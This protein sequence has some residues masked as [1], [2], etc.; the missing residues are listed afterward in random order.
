MLLFPLSGFS[1]TDSTTYQKFFAEFLAVYKHFSK[2]PLKNYYEVISNTARY[3]FS[4]FDPLFI[5][6]LEETTKKNKVAE[7]D[8]LE[9]LF[10]QVYKDLKNDFLWVMAQDIY[11]NKKKMF[12]VYS[13]SLCPCLTAKVSKTDMMEKF[14]EAQKKCTYEMIADTTFINN[15]KTVAGGTTIQELFAVSNYLAMYMYGNCDL[16]FYKF[17]QTLKSTPV[18][19]QYLSGINFRKSYE[20]EAAIR[21]FKTRQYDSLSLIFPGYKKYLN[22]FEKTISLTSGKMVVTRSYFVGQRVK[23][24]PTIYLTFY[25]SK[26]DYNAFARVEMTV[27]DMSLKSKII[28]VKYFKEKP[29]KEGQIIEDRIIEVKPN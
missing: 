11:Q 21:F 8:A 4:T 20:G 25:K 16:M 29:V 23:G 17:N 6:A 7:K 13:N 22:E 26:D 12:Q 28:S 1:Q 15:L 18:F 24:L 27:S 5:N 10:D 3:S 14:L 19:E 9:I 2:P